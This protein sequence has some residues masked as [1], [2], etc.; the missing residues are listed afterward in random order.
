MNI[1]MPAGDR[2]VVQHPHSRNVAVDKAQLDLLARHDIVA[3]AGF[4]GGPQ[5]LEVDRHGAAGRHATKEPPVR[6]EGHQTSSKERP[7]G[8]ESVRSC[9]SRWWPYH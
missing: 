4:A 9:I 2:A 1:D 8:K 5:F 3:E 7:V 6:V